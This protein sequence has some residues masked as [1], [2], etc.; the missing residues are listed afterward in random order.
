MKIYPIFYI[1]LLKLINPEIPVFTKLSKLSSENKYKI[2]KIIDYNYKNQ[3]YFVKW[4][5]YN[6]KKY[7]GIKKKFYRLWE[8][9]A[10]FW[11]INY[12]SEIAAKVWSASEMVKDKL[13]ETERPKIIFL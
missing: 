1:F 4:K 10:K 12:F 5:R 2:E 13:S 11:E 7:I 6:K 8:F 3:Q 9:G